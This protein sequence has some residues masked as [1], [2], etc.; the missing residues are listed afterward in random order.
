[1]L[2]VEAL[3]C[4]KPPTN[5]MDAQRRRLQDARDPVRQGLDRP[6]MQVVIERTLRHGQNAAGA[7]AQGV[8]PTGCT[9]RT[10]HRRTHSAALNPPASRKFP[11]P[12]DFANLAK[13]PLSYEGIAQQAEGSDDPV[14]DL[15]RPATARGAL[16]DQGPHGGGVTR[17]G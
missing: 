2:A 12:S 9:T 3:G 4:R 1:M 6:G 7:H 8:A 5:G 10:S 11:R 14:L 13:I 17:C 15:A 16:D